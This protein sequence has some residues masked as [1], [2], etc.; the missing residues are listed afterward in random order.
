MVEYPDSYYAAFLKDGKKT[1]PVLMDDHECDV[2]I[3]GGGFSGISTAI[4][5]AKKGLKVILIE[6][7]VTTACCSNY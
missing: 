7:K 6:E 2:C 3:I 5:C 4:E 1:Y